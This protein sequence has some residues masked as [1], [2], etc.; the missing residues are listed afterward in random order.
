MLDS[1]GDSGGSHDIQHGEWRQRGYV[2]EVICH[3]DYEPLSQEDDDSYENEGACPF[4][5]HLT[6]SLEA[7]GTKQVP[8]L[9][10]D[11]R[12]EEH[13]ALRAVEWMQAT[14]QCQHEG[15]EVQ[16]RAYEVD[17]HGTIYYVGIAISRLAVHDLR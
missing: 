7:L 5:A 2:E 10:H 6:V 4:E 13:G 16:A 1:H 15:R 3:G 9:Q 8:E 12:R 17:S 14:Q 11:E